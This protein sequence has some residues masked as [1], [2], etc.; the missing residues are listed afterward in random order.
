MPVE[1]FGRPFLASVAAA[2]LARASGC[3]LLGVTL[4]RSRRGYDARVLSE[5]T[6]ERRALGNR[7]ARRELTQKIMRAFEPDIREHLEQWYHFVPI[8]P[9]KPPDNAA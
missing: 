4:T 1:L 5:F 9:E 7:E 2:E 8:W 3:A 6:Y